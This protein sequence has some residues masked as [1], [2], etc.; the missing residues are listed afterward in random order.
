M[1]QWT[2]YKRSVESKNSNVFDS[3]NRYMEEPGKEK[4]EVYY[5]LITCNVRITRD[6]NNIH[7]EQDE[8][9]VAQNV[10]ATPAQQ[11]KIDECLELF[12]AVLLELP[13]LNPAMKISVQHAASLPKTPFQL[14]D[15]QMISLEKMVI[16]LKAL[17]D[18]LGK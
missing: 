9:K 18:D 17:E 15:T 10:S 1:T 8:K 13:N 12:N 11:G 7:L 3:F 5:D 4:S 14:D 2:R 6:L 16:E